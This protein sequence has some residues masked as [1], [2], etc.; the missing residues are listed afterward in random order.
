M[1]YKQ[2]KQLSQSPTAIRSHI[3]HMR[4]PEQGTLYVGLG[5]TSPSPSPV[6][7]PTMKRIRASR[8]QAFGGSQEHRGRSDQVP[9]GV[10]Y[11]REVDGLNGLVSPD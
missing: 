4:G 8:L 1:M 10:W 9:E 11:W 5:R 3:M 7:N 6:G 2:S